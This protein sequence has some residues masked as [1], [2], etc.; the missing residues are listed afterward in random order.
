[1]SKSK[2]KGPYI[3]KNSLT[4]IDQSKKNSFKQMASR[5][6]TVL[7]S[8]IDQTFEVYNGKKFNEIFVTEAMVGHKF[9]EFFPTRKRFLLKKKKQKNNINGT[10]NKSKYFKSRKNTR[11]EVK[12]Y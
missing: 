2:W 11:M 1:M 7:P 12:V 10:K 9:G 6:A 4:K 5:N 8:F 3:C